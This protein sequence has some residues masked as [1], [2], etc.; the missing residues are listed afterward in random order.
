MIDTDVFGYRKEENGTYT[1]TKNGESFLRGIVDS[2][3][4]AKIVEALLKDEREAE[5]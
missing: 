4:A 1:I 5:K 3:E 2:M